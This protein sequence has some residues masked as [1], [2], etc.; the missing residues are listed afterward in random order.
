M[1]NHIRGK[2]FNG[3]SIGCRLKSE[4]LLKSFRESEAK[5]EANPPLKGSL[6][7]MPSGEAHASLPASATTTTAA[8]ASSFTNA[9]IP[10][11]AAYYYPGMPVAAAYM[12]D[13]YG[14]PAGYPA[15][16][17]MSEHVRYPML[18][19]AYHGNWKYRGGLPSNLNYNAG[20]HGEDGSNGMGGGGRQ[21]GQYYHQR[22]YHQRNSNGNSHNNANNAYRQRQWKNMEERKEEGVSADTTEAD[23]TTPRSSSS[24]VGNLAERREVSEKETGSEIT[25]EKPIVSAVHVGSSIESTTNSTRLPVSRHGREHLEGY[26][27]H[28]SRDA[29][30]GDSHSL[31]SASRESEYKKSNG[32]SHL[33]PLPLSHRKKPQQSPSMASPVTRS[34]GGRV[35]PRRNSQ[36]QFAPD[37]FPSL[38]NGVAADSDSLSQRSSRADGQK[39]YSA[40]AA[41]NARSPPPTS[42]PTASLSKPMAATK[43]PTAA[44]SMKAK[45]TPDRPNIRMDELSLAQDLIAPS[46]KVVDGVA[47]QVKETL[48]LAPALPSSLSSLSPMSSSPTNASV[49]PSS[50]STSPSSTP[51]K[52]ATSS[53]AEILRKSKSN[54]VPLSATSTSA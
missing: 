10:P 11:Q 4:N 33:N 45:A 9:A 41:E 17:S 30:F 46:S 40:V 6:E 23:N 54:A 26:K 43:K 7:K 24:H 3:Q 53:Y 29:A 32:P 36:P 31:R 47:N 42:R 12:M 27:P 1:L 37:S 44:S 52:T 20:Y 19:G 50:S 49:S 13:Y 25:Q 16:P 51:T 28:S 18:P 22:S 39:A 15:Y 5:L 34:P 2:K 38:T 8:D 14:V 35:M 48:S 21:G